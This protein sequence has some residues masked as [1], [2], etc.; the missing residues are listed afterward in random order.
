MEGKKLDEG[1]KE[2]ISN[3]NKRR[4]RK[5]SM[6][7]NEGGG[8]VEENKLEK[9]KEDAGCRDEEEEIKWRGGEGERDRRRWEERNWEGGGRV[10]KGRIWI[11]ASNLIL[12]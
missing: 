6:R 8:E 12:D 3:N 11:V 1:V 5:R 9:V 7:R 2:G 10:M 4:N